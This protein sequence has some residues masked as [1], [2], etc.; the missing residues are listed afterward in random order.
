[1]MEDKMKHRYFCKN[2]WEREEK[3]VVKE[4]KGQL[5]EICDFCKEEM[6]LQKRLIGTNGSDLGWVRR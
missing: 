4:F 1:M 3:E 6:E 2:C 5:K